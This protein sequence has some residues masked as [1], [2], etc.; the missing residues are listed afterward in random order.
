MKHLLI[1]Q[2]SSCPA[3]YPPSFLRSSLESLRLPLSANVDAGA[4]ADVL[5]KVK[6][7]VMTIDESTGL[8]RLIKGNPAAVVS[9]RRCAVTSN[10]YCIVGHRITDRQVPT[11]HQ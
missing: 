6:A 3:V 10:E 2:S 9:L 4:D 5:I 11:T 1:H 7:Q 8:W